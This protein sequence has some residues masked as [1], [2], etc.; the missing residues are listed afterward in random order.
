MAWLRASTVRALLNLHSASIS[1]MVNLKRWLLSAIFQSWR[2]KVCH[3]S[4]LVAY[5]K[6]IAAKPHVR[7]LIKASIKP[8]HLFYLHLILDF[9]LPQFLLTDSTKERTIARRYGAGS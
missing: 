8:H 2:S 5:S 7:P 4:R 9:C 6:G 1:R 3:R